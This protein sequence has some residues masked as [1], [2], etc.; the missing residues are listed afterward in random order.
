MS[1]REHNEKHA[2]TGYM[3]NES[4]ADGTYNRDLPHAST[5][6][7]D[8]EECRTRAQRWVA[9]MTNERAVYRQFS[10]GAS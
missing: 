6:V 10:R 1:I 5:W 3:V 4:Q 9:A 8:R 2:A 7:C